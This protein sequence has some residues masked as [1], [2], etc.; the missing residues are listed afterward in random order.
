MLKPVVT[1]HTSTPALR[2]AGS[3][4]L[5]VKVKI[6]VPVLPRTETTPKLNLAFAVDR[7]GSM[8]GEKMHFARQ[9]LKDAFA[10]LHPGSRAAVVAFSDD[11]SVV[12]PS[13]SVEELRDIDRLIDSIRSSGMTA[14]FEGWKQSAEQVETHFDSAQLNRVL[15]LSDGLANV[16]PSRKEDIIPSIR[17]LAQRGISTT[18][19]GVGLDF[20][21]HMMEAISDAGDGTYF[22]IEHPNL[23]PTFFE[24]ELSGV[25]QLVATGGR[26]GFIPAPGCTFLE[27]VTDQPVDERVEVNQWLDGE[28]KGIYDLHML[29]TRQLTPNWCI[30]PALTAQRTI[31]VVARLRVEQGAAPAALG[32]FF[33]SWIPVG[34]EVRY[35]ERCASPVLQRVPDDVFNTY[36]EDREV[37]ATNVKARGRRVMREM[38]MD[39]AKNDV[40]AFELKMERLEKDLY[41]LPSSEVQDEMKAIMEMKRSI[42]NKD[43]ERAK[44]QAHSS[45]YS[46]RSS[47]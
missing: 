41:S 24:A 2:A 43:F 20:D 37:H 19:M 6:T 14:L 30:L 25:N 5:T 18:A 40:R 32:D 33:I 27:L 42:A 39:L 28:Q 38:N 34:D 7:S 12:L 10:Q 44:K 17:A 46:R 23:L 4:E 21:E 26:L 16:G 8:S 11:V 3:T 45:S 29:N 31:S 36:V 22:F 47:E 15:L 13:T 1:V 9:A 35:A